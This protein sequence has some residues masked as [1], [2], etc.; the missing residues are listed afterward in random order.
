MTTTTTLDDNDLLASI[1]VPSSSPRANF[2]NW[3]LSFECRPL[4][5]FEP[6]NAEQCALV[7]GLAKREGCVL[8]AVGVGHSPS[9]LACTGDFMLRMTKMNRL[10]EV[11]QEKSYVVVQAGIT[12]TDLH[13]ELAKYSLAMR[14]V[15]SISDQTL[16]GIVTTA[17]HG[18]GITFASMSADVLALT[19]LLADGS[20]VS[21]SRAERSDLFIATL[22]GLGS[23]GII[24]TIQLQVEPAFRLKDE[25]CLRTFEDLVD[26]F[27]TLVRSAEHVRFW[28]IAATHTV[29]CKSRRVWE[30]RN[31]GSKRRAET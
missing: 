11:N 13:S 12:L 18:S 2:I 17:S 4:A 23:T 28:W 6:E 14:N 31:R 16:G 20:V 26:N 22:C 1:T 15:G 24:L 29:K 25:Q 21:C 19:L 10:L 9:D 7:L 30:A 8:K 3:G 5:I 27:E